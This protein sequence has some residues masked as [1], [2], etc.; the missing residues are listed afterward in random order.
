MRLLLLV[1]VA[2]LLAGAAEGAERFPPPEFD[3]G[4]RT[5]EV[6]TPGRWQTLWDALPGY[7]DVLVLGA[8]LAVATAVI[9]A[10]RSRTAVFIVMLAALA[11]F[12]FWR[13][14]CVCPIGAI[15]N[16]TEGL[17][18]TIIVPV[19]VLFFFGLPIV[20]TLLFGRTFCGAVCPLGAVQDAVLIKN[21]RVPRWL[22]HSLGLLA[23]VYLGAAVLFAATGTM[24]LICEYDPFVS[25]F[26]IVDIKGT[27]ATGGMGILW[28]TAGFVGLSLFIGRPYCRFLCPLGAIFRVCGRVS[29]KRT[30]VTPSECIQCTLCEDACPFGAIRTPTASPGGASRTAGRRRLALLLAAVPVLVIGGGALGWWLGEPMAR[31]H[32][33]LKVAERV[34]LEQ[35]GLA[36]GTT[37]ESDAFYE[38][39]RSVESLYEDAA[40]V[41]Q[42]FVGAW[43]R[44][45]MT[46]REDR[47]HNLVV[48]V[49]GAA[50][51]FGAFCGFVVGG[52]LVHL[53]IRRRREDFEPDRA[54]CLSCGRCYEY[55]PVGAERG[56][57]IRAQR[58]GRLKCPH[59]DLPHLSE[60]KAAKD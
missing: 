4:Y 45:E 15:Q 24:Y 52:K 9:L 27:Q 55:C 46:R 30:T 40:Q 53:S 39:G 56:A 51:W 1:L 21:V 22:E 59:E 44:M 12:G 31:L 2:S 29:W 58:G 3:S 7:V 42:R 33:R 5:P 18:G 20:A 60:G 57:E 50:V 35:A 8:A 34:R 17:V 6:E 11:Y 36:E 16:V 26:R 13:K 41:T 38:T 43:H 48:W 47:I 25:L 32:P 54:T 23:Y 10:W 19:A 37:D 14:G 49:P 28:L